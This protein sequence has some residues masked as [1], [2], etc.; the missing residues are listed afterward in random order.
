MMTLKVSCAELGTV[1][2]DY[3]LTTIGT[4][5]SEQS[6]EDSPSQSLCD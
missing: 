6:D 5:E 2:S 1:E 3:G 4:L